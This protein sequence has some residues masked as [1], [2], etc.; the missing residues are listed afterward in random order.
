MRSAVLVASGAMLLLVGGLSAASLAF[1]RQ[2]SETFTAAAVREVVVEVESGHVT[3]LPGTG[4]D[5]NVTTTRHWSFIEASTG[6]RVEDGV[7]T[8]TAECPWFAPGCRVSEE[9][10]IPAGVAVR[11]ETAA[12]SIEAID[13]EVASFDAETAAGNVDASFA[14]APSDISVTT[15][16]G[17]VHVLVPADSYEVHADAAAGNVDV[18]V[19]QS[20]A[21]ERSIRVETS[22]GNIDI[23]AR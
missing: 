3:L 2:E 16:A 23:D 1:Q 14:S 18:G 21:S 10:V 22:A 5:V 9:L 12:G 7:L 20:A 11:V 8:V 4:A 17:N 13:V 6:H 15:S 19:A